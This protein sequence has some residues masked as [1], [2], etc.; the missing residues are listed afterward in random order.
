MHGV[1]LHS[2]LTSLDLDISKEVASSTTIKAQ[3]TLAVGG[4]DSEAYR[5]S[6]S[7]TAQARIDGV[8]PPVSE[9]VRGKDIYGNL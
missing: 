8:N 6:L 9:S 4:Y 5:V 1:T 2:Y 3:E 7:E